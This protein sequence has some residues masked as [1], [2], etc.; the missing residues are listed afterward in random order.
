MGFWKGVFSESDG[1]PSASRVLT[2]LTVLT[3]C[4]AFGH[5]VY[6]THA[7]PDVTIMTGLGGFSVAPYSINQLKQIAKSWGGP[8]GKT[9]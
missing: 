2:A 6:H 3:S 5:V 8:D 1:T 7:I 4:A 9:S